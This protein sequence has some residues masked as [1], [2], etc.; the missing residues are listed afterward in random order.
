VNKLQQMLAIKPID[1]DAVRA[2]LDSLS[3]D[4]RVAEI[5]TIGLRLQ[6]DLFEAADGYMPLDVDHFTPKNVPS[7]QFVKHYGKNSLP[8]FSEFEKHFARPLDGARESWGFNESGEFVKTV[9]GPGWFV[10]RKGDKDGEVDI[11]YYRIPGRQIEGA[12]PLKKNTSGLSFFVYGNMVDV[13]R[14]VS[15]HVTIGNA[16]KNG[17]RTDNYF[18]LSREAV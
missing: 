16:V 3:H 4:D 17:K 8:L 13:M 14:K 10:T 1:M 11:D 7:K 6:R 12:P 18:L 9:V 2:H 15:D 5:R